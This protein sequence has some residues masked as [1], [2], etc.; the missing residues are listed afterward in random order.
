MPEWRP[1][2]FNQNPILKTEGCILN[3]IL[4][5]VIEHQDG[6][7]NYSKV[8]SFLLSALPWTGGYGGLNSGRDILKVP[9]MVVRTRAGYP[10]SV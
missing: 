3:A 7:F 8:M 6:L 2:I 9:G 10:V 4:N 1:I 5:Y